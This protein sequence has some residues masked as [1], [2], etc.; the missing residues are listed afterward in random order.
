MINLLITAGLLAAW[1]LCMRLAVQAWN[2]LGEGH[3]D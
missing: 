1:V 3:D 2:G